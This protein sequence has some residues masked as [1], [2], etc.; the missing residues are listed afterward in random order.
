MIVDA[1]NSAAAA[2]SASDLYQMNGYVTALKAGVGAL[3][4]ISPSQQ[5]GGRV[6]TTSSGADVFAFGVYRA[7]VAASLR[8]YRPRGHC[9]SARG[10]TQ[11]LLQLPA[12]CLGQE[13]RDGVADLT[14]NVL[15]RAD[16]PGT[17]PGSSGGARLPSQ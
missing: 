9:P 6:C 4:Y 2:P 16:E 11:Y 8:S 5:W 3:V 13:W 15:L 12:D 17:N 7:S 14:C 10:V 1:K